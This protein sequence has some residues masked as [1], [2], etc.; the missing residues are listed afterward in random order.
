MVE[1][2]EAITKTP[3]PENVYQLRS[4]LGMLNYYHRFLPNVA[5][6]VE[7][8][9]KLLR[10]GTKWEWGEEQKVAFNYAKELLQS[11]DYLF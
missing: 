10:Q 1:K 8:L 6:V 11:A 5:T 3:D 7:H 9:H 4:F 2:V